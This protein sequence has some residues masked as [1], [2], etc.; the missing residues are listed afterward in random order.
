MAS[1][2]VSKQLPFKVQPK[3]E[4]TIVGNPDIGEL[5]F[6]RYRS[7]LWF[8]RDAL[9]TADQGFSLFKESAL[10]AAPIAKEEGLTHVEAHTMVT[11]ILGASLGVATVLDTKELEVRAKYSSSLSAL[12]DATLAWNDRRQIAGVTAVIANRLA[13]CE[14]WTEADTQALG[15]Q[16]IAAIYSFVQAEEAGQQEP[17][18]PD[19]EQKKLAEDLGKLR[20]EPG[21]PPPNPTGSG[22]TGASEPSTQLP[23]SSDQTALDLTPSPTSSAPS[24]RAKDKSA[25]D[26]SATNCPLP[27]S[28]P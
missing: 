15:E 8:E 17:S 20:P 23:V 25:S 14:D 13:G 10:V 11:R 19:E 7:L 4:T 9:R 5:E 27:N 24:K 3:Q 2:S 12:S 22:S 1:A 18:D 21:N 16:L 26:S 6:P 28:Q